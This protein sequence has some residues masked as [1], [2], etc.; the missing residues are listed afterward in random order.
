M[1]ATARKITWVEVAVTVET[2]R[3]K[4]RRLFGCV[5]MLGATGERCRAINGNGVLWVDNGHGY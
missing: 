3:G 4:A 1:S 2:H 5:R